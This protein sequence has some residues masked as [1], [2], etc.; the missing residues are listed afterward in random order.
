MIRL[1]I[2]SLGINGEGVGYYQKQVV[3]V[4]EAI[5][6]EYVAVRIT[7][8]K[9][10]FARGNI[11]RILKRSSSRVTAP[12]PV[13]Q[14]CGGCQ[15]QH[16]AYPMQLRLKRELVEEAFSR[17]TG[18]EGLPIHET[19]GMEE[20]WSYRNKAQLPVQKQQGKVV[21]GM[22]SPSSHRLIDMKGCLVQHPV[23]DRILD[24]ARR[25]LAD[26]SIPIYDERKHLG[27]IRH[28]V[29]R[30]G[31]ETKEAQLV[32]ISKENPLP[33]EKVL[34]QELIRRIPELVSLVVN[35]NP[36]RTSLVF[37]EKSRVLWGQ[38]TMAEQLG[39]RV[40]HLSAPAFFQLNPSQTVR[41]YN[42][43]MNAAGLTGHETVVDAYCGT[44]T[45]GIWLAQKAAKVIGM[46]TIA[47]AVV[48]ARENAIAN[49]IDHAEY[50]VGAAE[51]LLP[52]WADEGFRP[53]VVVA[54]P[55]R[56]GLGNAFI[57][58]LIRTQVARFVYVSCNPSTLAKDC[59]TLVQG[60]YQI[61]TIQP[62]DMFPQTAQV[63]CC[64]LLERVTE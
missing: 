56:T 7:E 61:R 33:K 21:M 20:P 24:I 15:L 4:D 26:L 2:R 39:D 23:T 54:D 51:E 6:G 48:D 5:P 35:H 60:G 17:Y 3:F 18:K 57:Q 62:V 55:P 25:T 36:Q 28:L 29:V 37:G 27:S 8:V 43:V 13:Y 12:C 64:V 49:G 32:L 44:G 53:D 46:D 16:I 40:F 19:L 22:Y 1:P 41:L 50:H 63:E 45:I 31:F 38:S 9:K 42:E 30:Y 14:E 47:E 58:A 34:Q 59:A 10:K 11:Q 52:R